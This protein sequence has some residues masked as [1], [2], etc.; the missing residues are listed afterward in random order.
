MDGLFLPVED[1]AYEKN[2]KKG[3]AFCLVKRARMTVRHECLKTEP[4]FE[5][6][7]TISFI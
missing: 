3:P 2:I 5:A 6:F 4:F 1:I 7:G